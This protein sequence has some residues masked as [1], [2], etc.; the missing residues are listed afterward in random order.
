MLPTWRLVCSDQLAALAVSATTR[1]LST[2]WFEPGT[3]G[4]GAWVQLSRPLNA[5]SRPAP[6][7]MLA[8]TWLAL[9][10]VVLFAT[11]TPLPDVVL[12]GFWKKLFSTSVG[13]LVVV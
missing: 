4:S 2:T 9:V 1:L 5:V 3:G 11:V 7:T 10:M 6:E 12:G 13:S 8:G